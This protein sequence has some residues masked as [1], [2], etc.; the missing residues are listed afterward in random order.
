MTIFRRLRLFIVVCGFGLCG[1]ASVLIESYME[2][3]DAAVQPVWQTTMD[4]A[5]ARQGLSK[6][7]RPVESRVNVTVDPQG[8]IVDVRLGRSSGFDYINNA[9]VETFK[10]LGKLPPPPEKMLV[11]GTAKL[12]WGFVITE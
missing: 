2:D 1:C 3:V 12:D 7:P 9:S 8:K 5:L 4:S 11:D 6:V 10:K